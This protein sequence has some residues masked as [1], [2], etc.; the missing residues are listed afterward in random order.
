[1]SVISDERRNVEKRRTGTRS[2]R[3]EKGESISIHLSSRRTKGRTVSEKGSYKGGDIAGRGKVPR[4][5]FVKRREYGDLFGRGALLIFGEKGKEHSCRKGPRLLYLWVG[6]KGG[7]KCGSRRKGERALLLVQKEGK[8]VN[9]SK[10]GNHSWS[11]E[12]LALSKERRG[13]PRPRIKRTR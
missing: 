4:R 8:E 10:K 3:I 12:R 13:G 5:G 6:K 9:S 7:T 11:A 1:V 2:A